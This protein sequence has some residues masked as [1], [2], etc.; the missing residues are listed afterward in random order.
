[1]MA[2]LT[3]Q[4]LVLLV[5]LTLIWGLNWPVMKLGITG[6]PP[7]AFRCICMAGGLPLLGLLLW[8]R[9]VPFH[10]PRKDWGELFRIS[11]FSMVIWNILIILALQN[12]SSGRAAILGYTMPIFAALI[13][14]WLYRQPLTPRTWLGVLAAGLAIVLLLWHE[15]SALSGKPLAVLMAL[16]SALAWAHGTLL[17]RRTTLTVS[18]FTI[19]F[20]MIAITLA[21]GLPLSFLLEYE[22]WAWPTPIQWASIAYNATLV[23]VFSQAIWLTLARHLP[24]MASS[25][26]VM[27]IPVIGVFSGAWWLSEVLHW[28]DWTAVCLIVGS[29]ASALWPARRAEGQT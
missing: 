21:F 29:I 25:L 20:W 27:F 5:I 7:L 4:Q 16:A 24:P 11:F 2:T 3:R 6:F 8:Q 14:W 9:R 22:R 26:S 1:M 10:V 17:M 13:G 18:T 12:L 28:Q 23:F 19:T 15:M